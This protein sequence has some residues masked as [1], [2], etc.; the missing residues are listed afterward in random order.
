MAYRSV[1]IALCLNARRFDWGNGMTKTMAAAAAMLVLAGCATKHYGRMGDVTSVERTQMT[2]REVTLELAKV[3]GFIQRVEKESE[4]NL[5]S[6]G[7]FLADF[8]LGNVLEKKSALAS[9]RERRQALEALRESKQC[10][11]ATAGD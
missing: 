11:A 10:G 3:D 9:A 2:C 7:S 4:F 1:K 8:G 6:V 5:R